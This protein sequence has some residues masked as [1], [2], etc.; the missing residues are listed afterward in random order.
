[1]DEDFTCKETAV[2]QYNTIAIF[3]ILYCRIIFKPA[4][5]VTSIKQSINNDNC[6]YYSKLYTC[7]FN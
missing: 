4:N 7:I 3:I 6:L 1:M 2:E 5:V